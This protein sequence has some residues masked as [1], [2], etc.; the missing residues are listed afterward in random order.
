MRDFLWEGFDGDK[1]SHLVS[2][3]VVLKP[4]EYGG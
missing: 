3:E 1:S 2:W 4:K